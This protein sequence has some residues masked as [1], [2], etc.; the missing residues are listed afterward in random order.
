M[1]DRHRQVEWIA[2]LLL[3]IKP[4][5]SCAA[6]VTTSSI[7]EDQQLVHACMSDA[8]FFLPPPSDAANSKLRSIVGQSN[9]DIAR[10]AR[11]VIDAIGNRETLRFAREIMLVNLRCFSAPCSTFVP[12]IA[13]QLFLLGVHADH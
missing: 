9:H 6:S 7:G 12:E 8:A 11:H 3:E 5:G 1:A 2:Q 4:P 10:V 13:D